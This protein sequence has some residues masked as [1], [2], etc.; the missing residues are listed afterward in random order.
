MSIETIKDKI[1]Y[2]V[3]LS[4]KNEA[5][6][7]TF[8]DKN[9]QA[10]QNQNRYPEAGYYQQFFINERLKNIFQKEMRNKQKNEQGGAPEI[11]KEMEVN[12][13]MCFLVNI[14]KHWLY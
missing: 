5:K 8:L 13:M 3:K 1:E 2:L 7:K 6:I 14:N 11:Q 9:K 4:F 12:N 10:N